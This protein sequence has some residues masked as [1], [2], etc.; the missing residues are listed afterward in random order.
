M[1]FKFSKI[2]GCGLERQEDMPFDLT[3]GSCGVYNFV[4]KEIVLLCFH[5]YTHEYIDSRKTCHK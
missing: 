4:D 1:N 3:G 5:E 2:I